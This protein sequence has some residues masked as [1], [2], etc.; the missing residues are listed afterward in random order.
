MVFN[1]VNLLYFVSLAGVPFV[2]WLVLVELTMVDGAPY[3]S[4]L[5][6]NT[7]STARNGGKRFLPQTEERNGFVVLSSV[8]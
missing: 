1:Y 4:L 7:H 8:R 6:C 3:L 5:Y 2:L